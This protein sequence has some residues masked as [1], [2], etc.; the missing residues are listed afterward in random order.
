M[1]NA[2][3][4]DVSVAARGLLPEE[5]R[6]LALQLLQDALEADRSILGPPHLP[7][8][9]TS[10]VYKRLREDEVT[11][12]EAQD[13]LDQFDTVPI[14]IASPPGLARLAVELSRTFQWSFP[15]DAFYLALGEIM[16]CDVWTAD[17]RF[18]DDA[19]DR[20]TRL[21]LLAD[22]SPGVARG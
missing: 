11:L 7:V 2:I 17:S 18:F 20:Y 10:A 16:D 3:S 14:T 21:R 22:Y 5:E 8:E 6:E 4:V 19:H 13:L 9:V 15:Y 12:E 1:T